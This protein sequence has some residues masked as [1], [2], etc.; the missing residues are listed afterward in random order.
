MAH[1]LTDQNKQEGAIC[2]LRHLKTALFMHK[3]LFFFLSKDNTFRCFVYGG[4]G[5][6]G[7]CSWDTCNIKLQVLY[8]LLITNIPHNTWSFVCAFCFTEF[9]I[10]L[11]FCDPAPEVLTNPVTFFFSLECLYV[12]ISVTMSHDASLHMVTLNHFI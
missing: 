9:P 5:K 12:L 11:V 7:T 1:S 3:T 4:A 10:K 8:F 2:M 6:W